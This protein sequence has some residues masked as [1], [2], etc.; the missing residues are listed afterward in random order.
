MLSLTRLKPV[1]CL[2]FCVATATTLASELPNNFPGDVPVADYM[3]VVNVTVVRD[4]MMVDLHAPGKSIVD[5][6]EWFKSGLTANGWKSEGE[7]VS[8]RNAILAYKKSN[9][10]CGVIVTNFVMDSSMQ[11]DDSIKGITLQLSNTKVP[12][13]GAVESSSEAAMDSATED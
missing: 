8:G 12:D 10:K 1:S 11:M 6:V 7:Q 3:Q 9:R 13:S 5:V 2:L 4:D